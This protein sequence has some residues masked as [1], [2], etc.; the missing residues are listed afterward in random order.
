MV[1]DDGNSWGVR[2]TSDIGRGCVAFLCDLSGLILGII[3]VVWSVLANVHYRTVVIE[4]VE[5][6]SIGR[7]ILFVLIID[8]IRN[9]RL[10]CRCGSLIDLA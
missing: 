1:P 10:L 6:T 5:C 7:S 4:R 8:L 9:M 2:T 3:I